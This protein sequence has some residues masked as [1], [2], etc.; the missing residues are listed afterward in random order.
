MVSFLYSVFLKLFY[1]TSVSLILLFGS[2]AVR[3]RKGLSRVLF[4]SGIAVLFIC[5]NGWLIGAMTRNLE[6]RHLPPNPM[7]TADAILVLSG[8][9]A[10]R[11]PPRPTVEVADAGDRLL[12]AAYLYKQGKAGVVI[13]TGG[14]ATGG[15]APRPAA[16][17]MTEFLGMVGVP[18]EA[19]ITETKSGDTHKH[20]INLGPMFKERAMKR[21]LLV[22]SALHM[23][24]GMGV[25]RKQCPGIEFIPAPT[26][27][28]V[29]EKL[30]MPWYR[31]LTAL[32]PTPS[33]LLAFSEAMHEY[34]GIARYRLSGWM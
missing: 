22:T 1:P 32:I 17:V 26:D 13:C 31:H 15:I 27:F 30:P 24:R 25:F 14:V 10:D 16:E 3:K 34:L 5:G 21:V 23:P 28:Q 6:W 7:P 4:W 11:I 19:I 8:G 20:A 33:H 12:Y 18:R 29:T 9:L 2:A